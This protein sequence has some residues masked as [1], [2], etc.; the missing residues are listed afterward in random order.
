MENKN[1]VWYS[2]FGSNLCED[3]FLCYIKGG[4][5]AGSTKSE[6]GARDN[7]S[8]V[9]VQAIELDYPL[10]FASY[11]SRWD[12]GVAFI[13][14]SSS[15]TN[16]SLGRMYLIT[17]EQFV[18]V[19]RQENETD[20]ITINFESILEKGSIMVRE[21]LYG[22]VLHVGDQDGIPIFTFTHK[23]DMNKRE[24]TQ[25]SERYLRMLISG[26]KEAYDMTDE[27]IARY[28]V[29]K[30]GVK[31]NIVEEE[32]LRLTKQVQVN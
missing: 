30:P 2:S 15:E 3:R 29:T 17:K 26:Y 28:L 13:G 19:V 22:N 1:Y 7:T 16:K 20:D 6:K 8:P 5:P 32:L 21:S 4:Q 25:P 9:D 12:G 23:E 11:S 14:T 24:F 10:Y 18:D 31:G 27:E